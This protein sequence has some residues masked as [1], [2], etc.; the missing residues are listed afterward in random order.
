MNEYMNRIVLHYVVELNCGTVAWS[1]VPERISFNS[2][3][4]HVQKS[5]GMLFWV[6][7]LIKCLCL[8]KLGIWGC[9]L[10]EQALDHFRLHTEGWQF[11][12][13]KT[14]SGKSKSVNF[15]GLL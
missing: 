13:L 6:W 5:P 10:G 3:Q 15:S 9:V 4:F 12:V 7:L 14:K 8:L 11:V 1:M 2:R